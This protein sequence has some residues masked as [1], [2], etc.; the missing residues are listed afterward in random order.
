MTAQ[1]ITP[2]IPRSMIDQASKQDL[3]ELIGNISKTIGYYI[4]NQPDGQLE[5]VSK[6][7]FETKIATLRDSTNNNDG[8]KALLKYIYNQMNNKK[9]EFEEDVRL[10]MERIKNLVEVEYDEFN[11]DR[12]LEKLEK[13][14]LDSKGF[15]VKIDKNIPKFSGS[16]AS[17][18]NID[19]WL[20]MIDQFKRHNR[21]EDDKMLAIVTPLLRGQALQM[22]KRGI[23]KNQQYDWNEFKEELVETFRTD[24][25]ERKIRKQLRELKHK[26]NFDEFITK[27]REL[28]M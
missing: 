25:R 11:A 12:L 16:G 24:T 23:L 8:S 19:D 7:T 17:N 10:V 1:G 2:L 4:A 28:S 5:E 3:A 14:K 20:F 21:V 6:E 9:Q 27:F 26:N 15:R 18:E 22:L 13:L